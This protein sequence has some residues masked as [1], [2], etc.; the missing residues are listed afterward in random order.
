MEDV[1][2]E[3]TRDMSLGGGGLLTSKQIR[4]PLSI[5]SHIL[6]YCRSRFGLQD[7]GLYRILYLRPSIR[8][9]NYSAHGTQYPHIRG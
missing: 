8:P 2:N 4:P 9:S 1:T 3:L 7:S 5:G 6:V